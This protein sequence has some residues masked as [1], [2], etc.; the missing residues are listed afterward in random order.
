MPSIPEASA[1]SGETE[2]LIC[3]GRRDADAGEFVRVHAGEDGDCEEAGRAG[4]SC[5][6]GCGGHHCGAAAGVD[7]EERRSGLRGGANGASDG[8]GYVVELEIEEDVEA[9]V[10]ELLD[11]AVAG[12]VVELHADL[13]P[14]AGL[15]EAVDELSWLRVRLRSRALLRG[16]LLDWRAWF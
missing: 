3:R 11:D 4:C 7:G 6:F 10:A 2:D 15:S 8:V 13:E 5:R 16:D 9:A 1:R 12:G 14:L